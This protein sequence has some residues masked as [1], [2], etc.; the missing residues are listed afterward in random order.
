M[1]IG[2]AGKKRSG[3]DSLGLMIQAVIANT[4]YEE[5][6]SVEVMTEDEIITAVKEKAP[7]LA[8][9]SEFYTKKF[10]DKLK[11]VASLLVGV[12]TWKIERDEFKESTL[13]E[14]WN[15]K[16]PDFIDGYKEKAMT[17]RK[18]L[19]KLGT[20]AIRSG[21]HPDTWVIALFN[22]YTRYQWEFKE[23]NKVKDCL[24]CGSSFK[25]AH[26][27]YIC[28]NCIKKRNELQ[29]YPN[30]I[31]T[32]VRFRNEANTIKERDGLL[33]R[34]NRSELHSTDKHASETALDNYP[35]YDE[36]ISNDGTL[37]DLLYKARELTEKYELI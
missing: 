22:D 21:L 37:K 34:I 18:F 28:K 31:I 27:Q 1:I 35:Y 4:V 17:G 3:K 11:Q 36:V 16:E 10:A 9:D 6:D 30:W 33:F 15:Y 8:G 32:D 29:E 14:E 2:I 23:G 24:D 5:S 26:I 7:Y 19:Q 13:G 25:G 20:E 12:P